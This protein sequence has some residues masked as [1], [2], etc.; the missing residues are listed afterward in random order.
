MTK[1]DKIEFALILATYAGA[2]SME[3]DVYPDFKS[4]EWRAKFIESANKTELLYKNGKID[5]EYACNIASHIIDNMIESYL[6]DINY[7]PRNHF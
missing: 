1:T 6:C 7:D 4:P 5:Y 3:S 2:K